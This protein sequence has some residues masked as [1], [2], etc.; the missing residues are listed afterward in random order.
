[1]TLILTLIPSYNQTRERVEQC[2]A[3]DKD[4]R[5][6]ST[7]METAKLILKTDV[8]I[9]EIWYPHHFPL[10]VL[11]KLLSI[12][13]IF[14]PVLCDMEWFEVRRIHGIKNKSYLTKRVR[15]SMFSIIAANLADLV[16][17]QDKAFTI[18]WK[19]YI[20]N[21]NKIFTISNH[22]NE[23]I[24]S[25]FAKKK[26]QALIVSHSAEHK[27]K[28]LDKLLQAVPTGYRIIW[29]GDVDI[30]T[31][32][33]Y[34]NKIDFI[35]KVGRDK[36]DKL[37]DES[38]ILLIPSIYEGSPRVLYEAAVSGVKVLCCNLR[39]YSQLRQRIPEL[40]YENSNN[41]YVQI[42]QLKDY[43]EI[44]ICKKRQQIKIMLKK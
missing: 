28:L 21:K 16:F 12:K 33:K 1:M 30:V 8:D 41:E 13:C 26:K 40:F 35:G 5:I 34:V 31:Q 42:A 39:G 22:F 17:V 10:L 4:Y 32:R 6:C 11:C 37:Y 23:R 14:S 44:N 38:E 24:V 15:M 43:N 27:I 9:V 29:A 20:I 2:K 36:L 18:I 19:K 7:F 25:D 3:I